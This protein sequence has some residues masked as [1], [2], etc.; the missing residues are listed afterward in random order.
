MELQ[1]AIEGLRRLVARAR[2]PRAPR[3]SRSLRWIVRQGV[4]LALRHHLQAVLEPAE[5]YVRLGQLVAVAAGDEPGEEQAL[6]RRQG[7]SRAQV[8]VLASMQEL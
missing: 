3:E 4:R 6:E 2:V 5:E 1:I 8:R 7:A